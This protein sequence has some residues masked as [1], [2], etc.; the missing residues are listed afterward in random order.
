MEITKPSIS[1]Q[2]LKVAQ[3]LFAD[4]FKASQKAEQA[5]KLRQARRL[6]LEWKGKIAQAADVSQ[7]TIQR[8]LKGNRDLSL[9]AVKKLQERFPSFEAR[10]LIFLKHG[11]QTIAEIIGTAIESGLSAPRSE[12]LLR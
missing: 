10:V 7:D 11:D 3:C 12:D 9:K 8:V 2:R 1:E 4:L 5:E 6:E